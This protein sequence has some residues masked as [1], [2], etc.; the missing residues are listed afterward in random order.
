MKLHP[1]AID[2]TGNTGGGKPWS[3]GSRKPKLVLHTIE[4]ADYRELGWPRPGA[5]PFGTWTSPP[6]LA[7]NAA[8]WP[9][10]DWL[11]QTVPFTL[12]G[13][14]LADNAG[15]VHR[16]V[17]QIEIAGLAAKVPDYPDE[18]YQ[19][20]A[21]VCQ[22][23]VDEMGVPDVWRDFSCAQFG[24][25]SPCRITRAEMNDFSGFMG[26]CHFGRGKDRH[27]DP[28]RLDVA[29]LRSFMQPGATPTRRQE[30]PPPEPEP[31]E[32]EEDD[33]MDGYY[34]ARGQT[35]DRS[36]RRFWVERIQAKIA[37]L[38]GGD[39]KLSNRRL[40]EDAGMTIGVNDEATQKLLT[41]WGGSPAVGPTEDRRIEE[42]LATRNQ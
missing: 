18:W 38:E 29:R 34:I 36:K 8:R 3:G 17:Y 40:I 23:F 13:K 9:D 20:L 39:S 21:Q 22:W 25:K 28:G 10:R 4:G 35:D 5:K 41:K 26:H 2:V 32:R 11:Y 19:A 31:V 30:Q 15:E 6:H 42:K 33:P 37:V 1:D 14:A 27:G 16:F 24:T 7:L 12:A